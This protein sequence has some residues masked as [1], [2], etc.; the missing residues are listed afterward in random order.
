MSLKAKILSDFKTAFKNK[1]AVAKQVLAMLKS[2]IAN[3]EIEL[4]KRDDGLDDLEIIKLV[5]QMIKQREES[6]KQFEQVGQLERAEAEAEEVNI[7]K[8]YLPAQMNDEELTKIV[9]EAIDE[10]NANGPE[11]LGQ[12]MK[13]VMPKIAGKADGEV[14]RKKVIQLLS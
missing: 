1:N 3:K 14:V 10:V 7:L 6:I 9:Q 12:V 2:A 5:R 4:G 11:H 13:V 8:A